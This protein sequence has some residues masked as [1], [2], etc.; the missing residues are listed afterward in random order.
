[1]FVTPNLYGA[2]ELTR[3]VYEQLGHEV[4]GIQ[5]TPVFQ[6]VLPKNWVEFYEKV[7]LVAV[8]NSMS[9]DEIAMTMCDDEIEA[10]LGPIPTPPWRLKQ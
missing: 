10:A 3:P 1:M 5:T 7:Y 9:L 6:K 8:Y 4:Y 2:T